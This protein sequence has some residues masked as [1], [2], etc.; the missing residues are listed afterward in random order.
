MRPCPSSTAQWV[1][2]TS[3]SDRRSSDGW[4]WI[5]L[6]TDRHGRVSRDPHGRRVL[7]QAEFRDRPPAVAGQID[8]PRVDADVRALA[9]RVDGEHQVPVPGDQVRCL[10]RHAGIDRRGPD[11]AAVVGDR[12]VV[13]QVGAADVVHDPGQGH[14]PAVRQLAQPGL[15]R[16][17]AAGRVDEEVG[18]VI[19]GR[20]AVV[21]A[22]QGAHAAGR[23]APVPAREQGAGAQDRA[24]GE[25]DGRPGQ[26][27]QLGPGAGDHGRR[28]PGPAV[29]VGERHQ[30]V[31]AAHAVGGRVGQHLVRAA[32][33]EMVA[34]G[35][36][37]AVGQDRRLEVVGVV[38]AA[39]RPLVE[40]PLQLPGAAAIGRAGH[41]GR[42][43]GGL[44]RLAQHEQGEQVP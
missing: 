8:Q 41:H 33:V 40:R 24:A 32:T 9:L 25:L 18:P 16:G 44:Q 1:A 2:S 21:A 34:G 19:P 43:V 39:R 29:V 30:V 22:Q 23:V 6:E 15:G 38:G 31:A 28:R 36:Q 27:D 3:V 11:G 20:A 7:P 10:R 12:D 14:D 35:D 42:A 37:P 4:L 17:V 5:E 26:L 13:G